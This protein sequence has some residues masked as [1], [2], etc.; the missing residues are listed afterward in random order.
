[1]TGRTGEQQGEDDDELVDGVA[2]DVLGH[3]AGDEG[4]VASVGPPLQQALRGRLGGQGQRGEGV[5]DEVH[6]Q[7]LHRLQRGVLGNQA[8]CQ[9]L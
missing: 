7:H 4:L 8:T 2:Q 6:P 3:G 9:P 5:H 1:M